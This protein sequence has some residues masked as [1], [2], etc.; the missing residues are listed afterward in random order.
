MLSKKIGGAKEEMVE[1]VDWDAVAEGAD[2]DE[3]T[4]MELN[5][6]EFNRNSIKKMEIK[7]RVVL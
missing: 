2:P 1:V 5:V 6:T 3:A 4:R 7:R